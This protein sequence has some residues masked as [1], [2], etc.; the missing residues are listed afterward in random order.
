M[1]MDKAIQSGK[2]HRKPYRKYCEQIDKTCRPG[3]DCPWCYGNRRHKTERQTPII[4]ETE[5]DTMQTLRFPFGSATG[6]D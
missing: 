4:E 5:L 2:E 3:G 1:S 6:F